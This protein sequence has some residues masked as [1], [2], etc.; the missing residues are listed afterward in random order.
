[1][2]DFWSTR[3]EHSLEE[4][5]AH[6]SATEDPAQLARIV[7]KATLEAVGLAA[8]EKINDKRTLIRL[9]KTAKEGAVRAYAYE[10]AGEDFLAKV[11]RLKE[12]QYYDDWETRWE[13]L[14]G[15]LNDVKVLQ[16]I[17][18]HA[19]AFEVRELAVGRIKDT[20]LLAVL[21]RDHGYWRVRRA[22]FE[23]LG[24]QQAALAESARHGQNSLVRQGAVARLDS[25]AL[26]EELRHTD[27]DEQVRRAAKRRLHFLATG[28]ADYSFRWK[29]KYP[30]L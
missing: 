18:E 16:D 30:A 12:C 10:K 23:A 19:H 5:L 1:M 4:L 26:L 29:R 2:Y 17:M 9:G 28:D 3:D 6:V 8:L 24:N 25:K 14:E 21:A 22:A 15:E 27:K 13:A 20:D 11:E 7:R